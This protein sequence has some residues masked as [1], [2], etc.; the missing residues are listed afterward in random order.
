M[1]RVL[2]AMLPCALLLRCDDSAF[3]YFLN[4]STLVD[5]G[6]LALGNDRRDLI[7]AFDRGIWILAIL[8]GDL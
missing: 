5:V 7:F 6:G 3:I 1:V 4:Q 8:T 2:E